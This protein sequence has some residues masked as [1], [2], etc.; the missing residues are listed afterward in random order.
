MRYASDLERLNQNC[1]LQNKRIRMRSDGEPALLALL[2]LLAQRWAGEVVAEKS[3]AGDVKSHGPVE[4]GVKLMKGHVP[5]TQ[6]NCCIHL[7]MRTVTTRIW[8]TRTRA[9]TASMCRCNAKYSV[10]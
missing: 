9:H 6:K 2:R 3:A 5:Q 8:N 10:V 4:N 1:K 7:R